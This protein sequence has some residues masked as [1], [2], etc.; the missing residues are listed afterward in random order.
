[1]NPMIRSI[2]T[3]LGN[4]AGAAAVITLAL[5]SPTAPV[6][7]E[8]ARLAKITQAANNDWT[9]EE[10]QWFYHASEGSRLMPYQWFVALE[11]IENE[12]PF[13]D[14]DHLAKFRV[15]PNPDRE[16]NP[17]GLPVG[18]ARD[19]LDPVNPQGINTEY[20]GFTCA[21]CHTGQINYKGQTLQIDGAPGQL[22]IFPFMG[23]LAAAITFTTMDISKFDRFAHKV[24]GTGYSEKSK[25]NLFHEVRKY[26]DEELKEQHPLVYADKI[27]LRELT[28]TDPGFGRMDALGAGSNNLFG[29]LSTKNLKS[30]DAPVDVLPLWNAY[31]YAWVQSIAA[32]RQPMARNMIETLSVFPYLVLPGTSGD[33][34]KAYLSSARLENLWMMESLAS[35]LKPPVWPAMFGAPD[36]EK[37][38]RGQVL[39][40][41]LCAKCHVPQWATTANFDPK[42]PALGPPELPPYPPDPVSEAAHQRSYQLP[43]FGVDEIG[44]D[45]GDAVNFARRH[46]D[47]QAMGLSAQEPAADV[48]IPVIDGVMQRYYTEH[49]IPPKEQNEWNGERGNY[50]RTPTAYPARPLAGIWA[51]AP[52]LHNGSVPNLYELL[53]PLDERSK[54]FYRGNLE[55]DPVRVGFEIREFEGGFKFDTSATGNSNAGHEFSDVARKGVIGRK[56]TAD[57]RWQI[58]E[59]LKVLK[60]DQQVPPDKIPPAGWTKSMECSQTQS[61]PSPSKK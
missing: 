3:K 28:V 33:A 10:R 20:V 11:Q 31:S 22:N 19:C 58:I 51:T 9:P 56:L 27:G 40:Q 46:V 12:K 34:Q 39:Y 25:K 15:I 30:L 37:A 54:T 48:I 49:K 24:L 44:T 14:P 42:W 45:P 8:P 52:F 50:W 60:F 61:A 16:N 7:A 29:M 43:L 18:F 21:A 47:A 35:R 1:M 26:I 23:H 55:F 41:E 59:Y 32:I 5:A 4:A 53:S 36:P 17:D 2:L 13:L 38:K 57:E 6:A